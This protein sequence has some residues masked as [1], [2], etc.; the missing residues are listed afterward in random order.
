[1]LCQHQISNLSGPIIGEL[2]CSPQIR[3][4]NNSLVQD[5]LTHA[6]NGFG[7]V[8]LR[9]KHKVFFWLLLKD[10]LSTRYILRRKNKVM[11]SYDCVLCQMQLEETLEHLFLHCLFAISCWNFL[12][13]HIVE[14]GPFEILQSLQVQLNKAFFMDIIILMIWCIWMA[15]NDLIFKVAV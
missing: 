13:L 5:K 7:K 3:P 8:Q 2:P 14:G 1:M 12:H 9:K 10:R 6:P 11:P 4:T 15:R